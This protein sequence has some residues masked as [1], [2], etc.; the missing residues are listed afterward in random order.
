MRNLGARWLLLAAI[1]AILAGVGLTYRNQQQV[2][3][4]QAPA[5]PDSLPHNLNASAQDW[6]W[7]QAS[8]VDGHTIVQVRAKTLKQEKDSSRLELENV[9]LRIFSKKGEKFDLVKSLRAEFRVSEN[10]LYSDGD[11]QITLGVPAEG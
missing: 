7:S 4:G 6:Q 9:E 8:P 2:L 5:K 3:Q 10:L 11:V 1:L